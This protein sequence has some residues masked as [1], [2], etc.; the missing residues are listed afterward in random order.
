MNH[1]RLL[2]VDD[3]T[4]FAA[5]VRKV[6][7]SAYKAGAVYVEPIYT[8]ERITRIRFEHAD[9]ESLTEVPNAVTRV[10]GS[11]FEPAMNDLAQKRDAGPR[12][13]SPYG[14]FDTMLKTLTDQ[15]AKGPYILGDRFT[16]ADLLWGIALAWT[17]SFRLVPESPVIEDY[18]DRINARPSVAR[19]RA[20]D[21]ELA[22]AQG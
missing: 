21:A 1:T 16:A 14:D 7:E 5:F 18:I 4:D 10:T 17:T 9:P 20:K 15:L 13:R 3:D 11:C 6:A 22:A 2:V 12:A 8:D 19:V